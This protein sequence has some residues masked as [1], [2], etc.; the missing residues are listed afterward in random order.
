MEPFAI[1]LIWFLLIDAVLTRI[2]RK[3]MDLQKEK[4]WLG[5]LL[6]GGS[7]TNIGGFW[8]T[9]PFGLLYVKRGNI[10][11]GFTAI[12]KKEYTFTRGDIV[13]ITPAWVFP[14]FGRVIR[15]NHNKALY[16]ERI[17]FLTWPFTTKRISEK[18]N[19]IFYQESALKQA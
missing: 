12:L 16:P 3:G 1:L 18:V 19:N 7:S 4:A 10:A 5:G 9:W 11:V 15:I 14:F 17:C 8:G 2:I 13:S 6:I